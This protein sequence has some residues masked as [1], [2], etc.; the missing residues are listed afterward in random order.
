MNVRL[1]TLIAGSF[2]TSSTVVHQEE[3][4]VEQAPK[5]VKITIEYCTK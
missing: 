1:T 3:V 5:K 4:I 2:P